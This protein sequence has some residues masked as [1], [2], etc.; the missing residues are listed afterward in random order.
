MDNRLDAAP[1]EAAEHAGS[2]DTGQTLQP[3]RKHATYVARWATSPG[4]AEAPEERVETH[5]GA[6][7]TTT[8]AEQGTGETQ[9]EGLGG[10]PLL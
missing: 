4:T 8:T 10:G 9:E 7:R 6:A 5:V 2:P 3:P 1:E